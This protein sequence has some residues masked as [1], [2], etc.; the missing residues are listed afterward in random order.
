MS[1]FEAIILGIVQGIT[2]FLPISSSGHL[3]LMQAFMGMQNLDQYI[4]FDLI[5]HLGTLSAIFIFFA[6][7]I[8]TMFTSNRKLFLQIAIATLPLVPV[9]FFLK[10]I[11]SFYQKPN[12]IGYFFLTT[13]LLLYLG[14]RLGKTTPH[15]EQESRLLKTSFFIG[16]FQALAIFPGISRSGATISGA[17]ILGWDMT[18]A[19]KFSFL[20]AIPAILGGVVVEALKIAMTPA[21]FPA[22]SFTSYLAGLLMSL[23]TGYLSLAFL[24]KILLQ[25]RLIYFALYC[26]V[27][28]I[29]ATIYFN[30]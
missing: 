30:F 13:S 21:V 1:T 29:T 3:K 27:L 11:E 26:F 10:P 4:F 8:R 7:E 25:K 15:E 19:L 20:L 23:V 5:C 24:Q 2:E 9:V 22:I 16:C 17:R 18:E 6:P 12:L 14:V 28:G